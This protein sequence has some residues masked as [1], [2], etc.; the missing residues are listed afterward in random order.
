MINT[1]DNFNNYWNLSTEI[2]K[3]N[4]I[5]SQLKEWWEILKSVK[6]KAWKDSDIYKKFEKEY[7]ELYETIKKAFES[8]KAF[9]QEERVK[10]MLELW[11]MIKLAEEK[12][13][14]EKKWFSS[15]VWD[16]LRG[17]NTETQKEI[18]LS[19]RDK[20]ID[21]YSLDESIAAINYLS[22][23]YWKYKEI[24][25]DDSI[26]KWITLSY[27][28]INE[29]GDQYEVRLFQDMLIEKIFWEKQKWFNDKYL[30]WFNN[31]EKW[32]YIMK[33]SDFEDYLKNPSTVIY[34]E[35]RTSNLVNS[36][37]LANYFLYLNSI[38]KA[39]ITY[40][41]SIL[42]SVKLAQLKD[43]LEK[44]PNSIVKNILWDSLTIEF[45]KNIDD[46]KIVINKENYKERLVLDPKKV[47]FINDK[48]LLLEA[49]NNI[50][51]LKYKDIN[52]EFKYDIETI[53]SF[54]KKDKNFNINQIP[55]N[56]YKID[57]KNKDDLK[58]IKSLLNIV[59]K[60]DA[61]SIV[62]ELSIYLNS[63]Q[64]TEFLK[65]LDKNNNK[66]NDL[67]ITLNW[68]SKS[69]EQIS[70]NSI[71]K[72]NEIDIN[73]IT[74]KDLELLNMYIY[75]FWITLIEDKI[76]QI[77]SS[78]KINWE[79]INLTHIPL[80]KKVLNNNL[81]ITKRIIKKVPSL[82]ES[83]NNEL[84]SN[85]AL[86]DIYLDSEIKKW[87]Y[88][89][90]INAIENINFWDSVWNIMLIYLKL[91]WNSY[92]LKQEN[93]EKIKSY[94]R[95]PVISQ[96]FFRF[97]E[98]Y[99]N[100]DQVKWQI[101]VL[102]WI[103][104]IFWSIEKD[105][106][107]SKKGF[108][109]IQNNFNKER[110]NYT[111]E[112]KENSN[113]FENNYWEKIKE[114]FS[115]LEINLN[116]EDIKNIISLIKN[117]DSISANQDLLFLLK[118]KIWWKNKDKIEKVF[119]G[120]QN[121]KIEIKKEEIKKEEEKQ[122]QKLKEAW[123]SKEEIEKV[124]KDIK[125]NILENIKNIKK[126][127]KES[128]E[129]YI[130]KI[131]DLSLVWI[132]EK[133]IKKLDKESLKKI[134]ENNIEIEETKIILTDTKTYFKYLERW[135]FTTPYTEYKAEIDKQTQIINQDNNYTQNVLNNITNNW[136]WDYIY[137]TPSWN[138]DLSLHEVEL[139]ST[140]EKA[141]ENLENFMQ[142]LNDLWL[143]NLSKYRQDIF[144]AISN[145][146]TVEFD[147]KDDF[148]NKTELKLFLNTILSSLWYEINSSLNLEETITKVK[149]FNNLWLI[150]GQKEIDK[151]W[152]SSL[153][154]HFL[155]KFDEKRVWKIEINKFEESIWDIL[156]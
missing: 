11:D 132:D 127:K 62:W 81:D 111:K 95:N 60:N 26:T 93:Q 58:K 1:L 110:Q 17:T 68:Y 98:Q 18:A 35:N 100:S 121:I 63:N 129:E 24:K 152:N 147:S 120:L 94:F 141:K 104:D 109:K 125:N 142:T 77:I 135:D 8:E 134:I 82:F 19:F 57:V 86:V 59:N 108:T 22:N 117:S 133:I 73:N 51:N 91:N 25:K 64:I 76:T 131:L 6:E 31:E 46:S 37:M 28:T 107:S 123:F 12:D 88:R 114:L 3:F 49:V 61:L 145:K 92:E 20:K 74:I 106:E 13:I 78:W 38:W 154:K 153:E 137:K 32:N 83:L 143:S 97:F 44:N 113:S 102:K 119:K 155:D 136:R 80:F 47:L 103:T 27:H 65:S 85:D 40:L 148:I 101:N 105:F 89:D 124:N 96:K 116:Q 139:I 75:K 149:D 55:T 5:Q 42:S 14:I 34:S 30:K 21:S 48:S 151:A 36:N 99:W 39:N 16:F 45:T 146:Y 23:N 53:E 156:K 71:S 128:S 150:S 33:I 115:N 67:L 138:I 54:I 50:P 118:E 140:N 130:E 66:E 7:K 122:T 69:Y 84:R 52:N 79:N 9:S 144:K 4:D 112:N 15:R 2:W 41:K 56:F 72:I 10:I 87:W 43:S 70:E 29:L 126:D 90:I